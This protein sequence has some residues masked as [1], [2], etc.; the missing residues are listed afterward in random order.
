MNCAQHLLDATNRRIKQRRWDMFSW[1][2]KLVFDVNNEVAKGEG[3][4]DEDETGIQST[5]GGKKAY[6][7]QDEIEELETIAFHLADYISK[8]AAKVS[9]KRGVM[10]AFHQRNDPT[11]VVSNIEAGWPTDFNDGLRARLNI[12]TVDSGASDPPSE[13]CVDKVH[14]DVR[15]AA[16]LLVKEFL[17]FKNPDPKTLYVSGVVPLYHDGKH[18]SKP[19]HEDTNPW[20]DRWND[21]QAW[22]PLY[23]EW[24]AKYTHQSFDNWELGQRPARA[25]ATAKTAYMLKDDIQASDQDSDKP[26]DIRTLSGRSLI[27]PQPTSAMRVHVERLFANMPIGQLDSML[28]PTQRK[29][30]L[31]KLDEVA[32]LSLPLAGLTDHLT[33]RYQGS[34]VKPLVRQPGREPVV[35]QEAID[36]LP[37]P[38]PG[39]DEKVNLSVIKEE[40]HLTPYGSLPAFLNSYISGFKPVTHGKMLFTKI[41]IIDKF[42][43]VAHAIDPNAKESPPIYPS[44]SQEYSID[45]AHHDAPTPPSKRESIQLPLAINQPT[46]LNA[47]FLVRDDDTGRISV[48]GDRWR[49]ST[50]FDKPIWGWVVV[51]YVNRGLQFFLPDGTFYREVRSTA[52][53]I[54]WLPFDE[55]PTPSNNVQLDALI[56][57]LVSH[58]ERLDAFTNMID[59]ALS[60]SVP[61]PSAYTQFM[62]SLV[63]RPLVL[64]N[65]GWSLELNTDSLKNEST[66]NEQKP[67]NAPLDFGLLPGDG[68]SKKQYKFRLQLGDKHDGLVGYFLAKSSDEPANGDGDGD[69][70]RGDLDVS[71]IY[72]HF[73]NTP[74]PSKDASFLKPIDK[75]AYPKLKAFWLKPKEYPPIIIKGKDGMK[76][77]DVVTNARK[78]ETKRNAELGKH[79]FGAVFD[80]FAPIT[81]YSGILPPRA[82]QLPSWMWETALKQ[83]TTFFHAGPLLVTEPVPKFDEK[84][85]LKQDSYKKNVKE[86]VEGVQMRIPALRAADWAWLQ[87]Y[88]EPVKPTNNYDDDDDHKNKKPGPG[89][90]DGGGGGEEASNPTKKMKQVYMSIEIGGDAGGDEAPRWKKGPLTA[91]EGFMQ[92]KEPVEQ[93]ND[94]AGPPK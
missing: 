88:Y 79:L 90:L 33:T 70:T 34:H 62:N 8:Q 36:L 47:H 72:T 81:G 56:D 14:K 44:V 92:L 68:G 5:D 42:G 89:S 24:E 48:S 86:S 78:F 77:V 80:P 69:V 13:A 61:T 3:R 16:R 74:N 53:A 20:R 37:S 64:A 41:N 43:Q 27:L 30:I 58:K 29:D 12:Q 67:E 7:I 50:E 59:L 52:G 65:M 66:L 18:P 39:R 17:F 60:N 91:V 31:K 21:S 49:P 54:K 40:S 9:A 2:W 75:D 32:M 73:T 19:V 94:K 51:N 25:A 38:I 6:E 22:F 11:L 1:W 55:P 4:Q 85:Q 57:S 15:D 93:G 63:G 26:E 87:P 46:R 76:E 45:D 71:K 10:E 23:V 82:L 35:L 84:H 28:K 83:I